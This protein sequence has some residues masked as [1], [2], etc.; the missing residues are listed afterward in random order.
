MNTR[1]D[2]RRIAALVLYGVVYGL[3]LWK[4]SH[5]DRPFPEL[6]LIV[7]GLIVPVVLAIVL[8]RIPDRFAKVLTGRTYI[9]LMVSLAAAMCAMMSQFDPTTIQIGR[10]PA[11]FEWNESLFAGMFPYRA[12]S[13]PSGFPFLFLLTTP[14]YLLGE[15]GLLQVL[16]L[17]L[18]GG[19]VHSWCGQE[20][21]NR[22]RL[23]L[24]L[25]ATP[26]F[27]F[28]VCVRSELIA[29]A[30]IILTAIEIARRNRYRESSLT[31]VWLGLLLG[32]AAS[33]RGIFLPAYLI[34]LPLLL[35][36]HTA[37][38]AFTLLGSI[39]AGFALTLAPFALWDG[40][41]FWNYGPFSV[42]LGHIP[43][44]L[45]VLSAAVSLA[46][47][48][49][50]KSFRSAYLLSGAVLFGIVAIKMAMSLVAHGVAETIQFDKHFEPAYFGF[51][52]P[53]VILAMSPSQK[54]EE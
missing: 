14:F 43:Y 1:P 40:D 30:V 38:H 49:R 46:G 21:T 45:L 36:Q 33:T 13:N 6:T 47:G 31:P 54:R 26:I 19:V 32:L 9:L 17:V 39:A 16:G 10:Y 42:Q 8:S 22:F 52:L 44:W 35:R 3:Y 15:V 53:F 37:R 48:L 29:N 41:Y 28:E 12:G 27:A 18:F 4:F 34:T 51:A 7:F 25:V 2:F 23:L 20:S 5:P 11:L 24:L 50:M